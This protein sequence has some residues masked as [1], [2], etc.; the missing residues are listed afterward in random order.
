MTLSASNVY[1][2][3]T[4]Y[5]CNFFYKNDT[6]GRILFKFCAHKYLANF[7]F[8]LSTFSGTY[9]GAVFPPNR[10]STRPSTLCI[11]CNL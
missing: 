6:F 7:V 8:L 4:K 1:M 3:V 10:F 5:Y 11:E 9:R 2:H